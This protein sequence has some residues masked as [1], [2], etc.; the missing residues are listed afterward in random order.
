MKKYY[1][2]DALHLTAFFENESKKL[3]ALHYPLSVEFKDAVIS[4]YFDNEKELEVV[5]N[6]YLSAE[7][8]Y[9]NNDQEQDEIKLI[10]EKEVAYTS[11]IGRL[12]HY[13]G[14]ALFYQDFRALGI[15]L[16]YLREYCNACGYC[17]EEA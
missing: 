9:L 16:A 1:S 5:F 11:L 17:R 7:F 6:E 14:R 8:N 10:Q 15:L 2:I 3:F 13:L 12:H 4:W